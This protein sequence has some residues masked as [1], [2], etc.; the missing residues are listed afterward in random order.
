MQKRS[1]IIS[2][3]QR[4]DRD[5]LFFPFSQ[6]KRVSSL[7]LSQVITLRR[8]PSHLHRAENHWASE[9]RVRAT[10]MCR[11]TVRVPTSNFAIRRDQTREFN[12][13]RGSNW[14]GCSNRLIANCRATLPFSS[15]IRLTPT[16]CRDVVTLFTRR[17]DRCTLNWV[18]HPRPRSTICAVSPILRH[19]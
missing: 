13:K 12:W 1:E 4:R 7:F 17:R 10:R 8:Y 19:S 5:R 3:I 6:F 2:R 18:K 15:R 9:G 14:P 16:A 11:A